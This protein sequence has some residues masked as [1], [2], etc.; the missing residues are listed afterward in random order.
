MI[1]KLNALIG[2]LQKNWSKD[3]QKNIMEAMVAGCV[4]VAVADDE[5]S[6][7]ERQKFIKLMQ[8]VEESKAF[9]DEHI[10]ATFDRFLER[11]DGY[12]ATGRNGLLAMLETVANTQDTARL[13]V[14]LCKAVGEADGN[15][16]DNEK[17]VVREIC[18]RLKLNPADFDL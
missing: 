14:R 4:L 17:A 15:F 8:R 11:L 3:R 1:P 6:Q 5:V 12:G 10:V 7:E 16:D 18:T 9:G 2:H 13:I